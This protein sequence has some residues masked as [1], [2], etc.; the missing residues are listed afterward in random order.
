MKLA[1]VLSLTVASAAS[2]NGLVLPSSAF[3]SE[4]KEAL[5]ASVE[6]AR[7]ESLKAFQSVETIVRQMPSLDAKKRG[8][9]AP[10]T[11]TMRLLGK[12][13]LFPALEVLALRAP[14]VEMN[15]SAA[16]SLKMGLIESVGEL[17]DARAVPVL[18]AILQ[19]AQAEKEV[20]RSAGEALGRM[21][22]D[23]AAATLISLSRGTST[24]AQA[25]LSGMGTCRRLDVVQ[26]L[27]QSLEGQ[28]NT[29]SAVSV[30][31][32]LG[33]VGN[34]WAWRLEPSRASE[35]Q[36]RNSA[37]QALVQ[38]FVKGDS[39]VRQ[40]ASNALMVI[41]APATLQYVQ[42]ATMNVDDR[43]KEDLQRHQKRFE[44]N[45]VR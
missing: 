11:Q 16:L 39:T 21:G 31:K 33:E 15:A 10:I 37:A 26:R 3:S 4:D 12:D 40:A 22:T 25:V 43:T 27:A 29:V 23:E 34:S 6:K 19:S 2:A 5:V 20:Y 8:R 24:R 35:T 42:V 32:S 14:S 1:L 28:S 44:N 9:Y 17:K 45:P 13:L 30:I 41:D 18:K 36:V 38:A 7:A